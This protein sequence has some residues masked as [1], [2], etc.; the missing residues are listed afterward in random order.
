MVAPFFGPKIGANQ[1]KKRKRSSL[2]NEWVFSPKVCEDQK[3]RSSP[4]NLWVFGL[5][6]DG[7]QTKRK[8]FA[9]NRWS[10]GFTSYGDTRGGPP[11][12]PLAM[13]LSACP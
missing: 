4:N 7:N 11:A 9:T 8:V 5:N 1:K 10:Y 2:Q 13:P 3:K 12:Y 6:E